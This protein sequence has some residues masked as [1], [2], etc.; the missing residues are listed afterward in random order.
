[1]DEYKNLYLCKDRNELAVL[2]SLLDSEKIAYYVLGDIP[3][4]RSGRIYPQIFVHKD[5]FDKAKELL[6]ISMEE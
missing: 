1:M 5:Y 3:V 2:K 6:A 4:P